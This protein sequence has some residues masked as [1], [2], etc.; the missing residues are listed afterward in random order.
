MDL[1]L[2][3]QVASQAMDLPSE[4]DFRRWIAAALAGSI[5][6]KVELVVR[7]VDREEGA[8]LNEAYRHRSGPTNVLSFPFEPLPGVETPLLGDLVI[9]APIVFSEAKEQHKMPKAHWAHLVVHGVLH[10][11]GYDH[12]TDTQAAEMEA[13]EIQILAK[14]GYSNPY[15]D[16]N[17]L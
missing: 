10:L 14:L 5:D 6:T 16:V 15:K 17:D 4:A 11:L 1:S 3:V 12:Q 9:C 2:A 8:A 7:I 13:R